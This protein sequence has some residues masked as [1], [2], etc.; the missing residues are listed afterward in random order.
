MKYTNH[1]HR[2]NIIIGSVILLILFR[3]QIA[4]QIV[5]FLLTGALP[6]L[7][8]SIPYWAML[9]FYLVA[10]TGV[11]WLYLDHTASVMKHKVAKSDKATMPHRRYSSI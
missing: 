5:G 3:D 6:G 10:I 1:I 2:N 9:L 7:S 8:I 4:N 11:I